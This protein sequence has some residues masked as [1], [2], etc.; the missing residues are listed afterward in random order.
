MIDKYFYIPYN[1]QYFAGQGAGGEK[2][3]D[4]TSKKLSDARNEGQVA[5][6]MELITA[7][8]LL[9]M[10]LTLK[11]FIGS[12][13]NQFLGVY[14]EDFGYISS[15]S[16]DEF[17]LN[18]AHA[19]FQNVLVQILKIGLPIY[20]SAFIMTFLI[21]F[22]QVKWKVS[23]KLLQPKFSKI[24]P[25]TGFK[26]IFSKDK[27]MEL[28]ISIVKISMI[29]YVVYDSLKNQW[30]MILS[31][32]EVPLNQAVL[33]IG[34]T[35]IGLGVKISIFLLCIGLFDFFYQK[36]KF[37]GDMKMTKQEVKDEYKQSE[38]DP[39]IKGKIRQKMREVSQRRMMQN[40]PEADVVITNPTHLAIAIKY[41][42]D[43][44]SAPIVLAKGADY[45]ALKIK[46]VAKEN[47]IEIVENKPLARMLY[48]NVDLGEEIPQE[49]Y[50]MVAEVLA[51]VYGLKEL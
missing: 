19:L 12:I 42:K 3:E 2:T 17:N 34:D 18:V 41:D 5:K 50:Q 44:S 7:S 31:L 45:M 11:F 23:G 49:L 30:G 15:I 35:V 38:G 37:K 22:I 21:V 26:K 51:Y 9:T 24:N 40:L 46:E 1:L 4:A 29:G 39:H 20:L 33:L 8:S 43:V 10:F 13:G 32:Y 14:K 16:S 48:Y 25:I 27:L 47:K 28:L 36:I 6:S